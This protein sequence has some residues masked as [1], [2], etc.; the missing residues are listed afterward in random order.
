MTDPRY[1]IG[2]FVPPTDYTPDLRASLVRDIAAAPAA[3]KCSG[4]RPDD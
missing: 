2:K 1:P 4:C 3:L